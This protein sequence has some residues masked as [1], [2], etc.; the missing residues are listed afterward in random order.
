[1]SFSSFELLDHS[2]PIVVFGRDGQVGKAVQKCLKDSRVPVV[3]LGRTD[4][5]LNDESSITQVLNQYQPQVII[6]AAAYTAVDKA[7]SEPELAYAINSRAPELMAE[8]MA[9]LSHGLL[10]HYS[11]DYVFGDA[12]DTPYTEADLPGPISKLNIYGQTKLSGEIAIKNIFSRIRDNNDLSEYQPSRYLILRTSWAYGD[13]DNFIRKILYLATSQHQLNVV[14]DQFG[15]PTDINWLAKVS[16]QIGFSE[17]PSGVYHVIPDG[18]TS[19]YTFAK[20]CIQVANLHGLDLALQ[21]NDLKPIASSS[22]GAMAIRPRNSRMSNQKLRQTLS[23][24]GFENKIPYWE[25]QVMLY[26]KNYV[27]E[28]LKQNSHEN[29]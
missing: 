18:E 27:N 4:C 14:D 16:L 28:A 23:V 10:I 1:M 2:K 13:G 17:A 9:P 15:V 19:W 11:A 20:L 7:E 29:I 26:V 25:D 3:F 24:L 8:Y 21:L 12:Q 22:Y 6:N 5:D